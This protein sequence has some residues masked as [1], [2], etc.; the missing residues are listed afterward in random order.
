[1]IHGVT[2]DPL[3]CEIKM[4]IKKMDGTPM[5]SLIEG[6]NKGYHFDVHSGEFIFRKRISLPR[7]LANGDYLVDLYFVQPMI[8]DYFFAPSCLTLHVEGFYDQF[9]DPLNLSNEGF[10]GL[11]SVEGF[12]G[13]VEYL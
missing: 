11:E 1:M 5:A 4:I 13:S 10:I 9:G 6:R 12:P 8:Q 7:Y 2:Q 3:K